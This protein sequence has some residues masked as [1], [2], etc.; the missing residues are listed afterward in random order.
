MAGGAIDAVKERT[1]IVDLVGKAVQLRQAGRYFKGRCPFH[2]EKTPSFVVY[3][4][5]Q[6]YHCFGCGKTGDIFTW[7]MET[8]H[9]EFRDALVNLA[10][11]AGVQLEERNTRPR[12]DEQTEQRSRLIDLNER[13]AAWFSNMLWTSPA[14]EHAR[15]ELQR[16]GVDRATAE[17]FGLGYAPDA[18]EALKKHFIGRGATE[19]DLVTVGLLTVRDDDQRSYDRFRN[20]I[21]FPI[22]NHRAEIV[23]FGGRA[24]GE[25]KPKYLNTA[26][27]PIFNKRSLLYGLDLALPSIR[28]LRSIVI[29]EG[30]M[31]AIA[32]HQFGYDNVVASM[33]TAL[34]PDQVKTVRRSVDRVFLALDSDAA[35]QMA[36]MRGIEQMRSSLS[37][38][39]RAEVGPSGM[40]RFENTLGAEVR[41]V[42]LPHGKDP[43]DAIRADPAAWPRTVDAAV[44][45]AEFVLTTSLRNIE[46]TPAARAKALNEIAI[47]VLRELADPIVL[48]QY[49]GLTA[50]LLSIR[51]TDI[52]TAVMRSRSAPRGTPA[53]APRT[54]ER[55]RALNHERFL[56]SLVALHPAEAQ[57]LVLELDNADILDTRNRLL[58]DMVRFGIADSDELL[59]HLDPEMQEYVNALLESATPTDSDRTAGRT[60]ELQPAIERLLRQRHDERMRQAQADVRDAQQSG[61][62]DALAQAMQRIGALAQ[63]RGTFAPTVSPYFRDSRSESI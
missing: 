33:G 37:D 5:S 41:I 31:D 55:P 32:A 63:Q 19:G 16:R 44:P 56:A 2:E 50:N 9:L 4:D 54:P 48:S 15:A 7:V 36:T 61:D 24:M 39:K 40:V 59:T 18:F 3:P 42:L 46:P 30:Y 1:D 49:V 52:H 11:R 51:D 58:L 28:R 35:G 17:R 12:D 34:T 25:G 13:A 57:E 6:S 62:I 10:E 29:V 26:E 45:L 23:G 47:P 8:E 53:P 22:R 21:M 20:R 14:G 27:T 60:R 38:E 43:D